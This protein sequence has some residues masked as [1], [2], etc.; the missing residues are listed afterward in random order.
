MARDHV[1]NYR[2]TAT[3]ETQRA[4]A[5]VRRGF[6]GVEGAIAGVQRATAGLVGIAAAALSVNHFLQAAAGAE[7]ASNRLSAVLRA[8]G[9]AAGY[10]K[11]QLD[12][13]ADSMAESTMFDDESI[14]N[15]QS[16]F[17][18]FGNIQG[19]VFARG[20]KLAADYASFTGGEMED[21]AQTIGKALQ[22]P[23][24]GV[25]ALERQIGKLTYTQ[26]ESIKGFMEQGR[27]IEAQNL[28]LDILQKKIGGTSDLMNTGLTKSL[29]DINKNWGEFSETVGRSAPATTVLNGINNALK[30]MKNTIESGDWME[31][32]KYAIS[33]YKI[34]TQ[35]KAAPKSEAVSGFIGGGP[36]DPRL[37]ARLAEI[38]NQIEAARKKQSE[39][40][41]G[42]AKQ[43]MSLDELLTKGAQKRL[44]VQ[45]QAQMD[46]EKA[47]ADL[48]KE[49]ERLRESVVD[50]IDPSAQYVKLLNQYRA[51]MDDGIITT[52]QYTEAAFILNDK[53]EEVVGNKLPKEIDKATD[54]GRELGLVFESAASQAMRD[55][56]GVG[57]LIR[58]IGVD[59]AQMMLKKTLIDP[60]SSFLG[61]ALGSIGGSIGGSL[62]GMLTGGGGGG[63][64]VGA[65][66]MDFASF[67]GGGSTG[68]GA[69]AGGMDGQGGF[70][71]MLHPNETVIDHA[72][73][74]RGGGSIVQNIHFSANTPAAV[75]DAVF[76]LAPQLTQASI[77][78]VRDER[79]RTG[80]RR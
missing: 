9:G 4:L 12:A 13:M 22:S 42:R 49:Q 67:A 79:N 34:L 58:S 76:A 14:R 19:D 39:Q 46:A 32:L 62:A 1:Q 78:A 75:R 71:A 26:K 60:A 11:Q 5:S 53:I 51:A 21:A 18:K 57:N 48:R 54:S 65:G 29:K 33:P 3:D 66:D 35:Q 69:R 2:V 8:T 50:L 7:V 70:M 56:Q 38:N 23:E 72:L 55:W 25:G 31:A 6:E 63:G 20:M 77:A 41:T 10:T 27:V 64:W 52:E 36:A 45:E 44:E 73:G 40:K 28:V 37:T 16:S 80:D 47:A 74:Q 43:E 15:A 17:L 30:N 59:I 61:G 68:S 24:E